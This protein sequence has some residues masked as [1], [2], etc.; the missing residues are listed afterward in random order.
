M[1]KFEYFSVIKTIGKIVLTRFVHMCDMVAPHI[2]RIIVIE[3][4][5]PLIPMV[6]QM[7][8]EPPNRD[9]TCEGS[10]RTCVRA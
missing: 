5:R 10:W 4:R 8:A 1:F 9:R 2:Y 3:M 7:H 6:G